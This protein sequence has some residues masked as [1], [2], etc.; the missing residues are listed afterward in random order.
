MFVHRFDTLAIGYTIEGAAA[1][2]DPDFNYNYGKG[3]A[4]ELKGH[5]TPSGGFA[6]TE[7][8]H[9]YTV[10]LTGIATPPVVGQRYT[11]T[12]RWYPDSQSEFLLN[13]LYEVDV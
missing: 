7:A 11:I 10:D 12:I 8:T 9:T 5:T 3:D 1:V 13:Y 6:K 4:D 2:T